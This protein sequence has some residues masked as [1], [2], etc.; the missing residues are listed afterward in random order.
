MINHTLLTVEVVLGRGLAIAAVIV[1]D[2]K[3]DN[4]DVSRLSNIQQ[5]QRLLPEHR[6]LSVLHDGNEI[7]ESDGQHFNVLTFYDDSAV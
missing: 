3:A 4:D 2:A 6:I 7:C 5:L 1:N